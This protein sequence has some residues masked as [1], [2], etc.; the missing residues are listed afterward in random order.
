MTMMATEG[1]ERRGA[2]ADRKSPNDWKGA[3]GHRVAR[4]AQ[5]SHGGPSDH[6]DAGQLG[7]RRMG[8]RA[9]RSEVLSIQESA[10]DQED[11]G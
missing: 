11:D 9:A 8:G 7:V 3:V 6:G 10:G 5:N 4:M 1:T 2:T